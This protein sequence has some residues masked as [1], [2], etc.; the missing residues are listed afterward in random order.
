LDCRASTQAG[1]RGILMFGKQEGIIPMRAI[2]IQ[3]FQLVATAAAFLFVVAIVA[4]L[5]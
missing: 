3:R 4:G 5:I 2:A 1:G